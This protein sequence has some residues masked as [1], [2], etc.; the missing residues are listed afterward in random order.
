MRAAAGASKIVT[1]VGD[2]GIG[3][4]RLLHDCCSE[5]ICRPGPRC[6]RIGRER[7]KLGTSRRQAVARVD[8]QAEIPD[9]ASALQHR[10]P[11]LN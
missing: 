11:E 10:L 6:D 8:A 5:T 7:A 9:L 3:K 1:V 2:P 4:S